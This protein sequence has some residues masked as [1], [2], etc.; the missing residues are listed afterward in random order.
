MAF[1]LSHDAADLALGKPALPWLASSST[2]HDAILALKLFLPHDP[3]ISVWDC[4]HPIPE[5]ASHVLPLHH[6]LLPQNHC[7]CVG[8]ISM[9]QII[10]FLASLDSL[11]NPSQALATP[12]SALLAQPSARTVR[13][14]DS[15]ASLTEVL[16]LIVDG[17]QNL[18]VQITSHGSKYVRYSRGSASQK[19][20]FSKNPSAPTHALL[21][22]IHNG[23]EY[24]WLTHEDVLRFLLGSINAFSPLP[25]MSINDLGII[26]HDVLMV[27]VEE[28][29]IS[30]LDAIKAVG[31]SM[32]AVAVV[33]YMDEDKE[34]V[35]LVGEISCSAL[36]TCDETAA[37]AL[38]TLS[39]GDF[40]LYIQDNR[41]PPDTLLDMVKARICE[42]AGCGKEAD[43]LK[44]GEIY[45]ARQDAEMSE[46]SS[47]DESGIDSPTGPCDLSGRWVSAHHQRGGRM[48]GY[49]TK[50]R[51]A[52]IFCRPWNSLIAVIMQALAHRE[53][54]V[55]VTK[56]DDTLV[57][58][59][60]F[61]DIFTVL[62]NHLNS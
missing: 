39:V 7:H 31:E 24:C 15:D 43:I 44:L 25:M 3:E 37:L 34:T 51:S 32:T 8:K 60:T 46:E 59:V 54:Y 17:A 35:K 41:S 11:S 56:E 53:H 19:N 49:S 6:R 18:V 61:M 26:K 10:C 22:K 2:V 48:G 29:A 45:R 28:E 5:S 14:V 20:L 57:G 1:V 47:D 42:K 12:L 9:L 16:N 38:A 62:L 27:G 36:Q 40:L 52:P 58:I 13:H 33:E 21:P 4:S 30:A 55:W 23:R 50:I